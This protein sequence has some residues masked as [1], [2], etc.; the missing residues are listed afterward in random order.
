MA[1]IRPP[2]IEEPG[3]GIQGGENPVCLILCFHVSAQPA[4]LIRPRLPRIFHWQIR[5]HSARK[6]GPV[7]PQRARQILGAIQFELFVLKQSLHR[8]DGRRAKGAPVE[9]DSPA[10]GRVILHPGHITR[11]PW[12]SG[13]KQ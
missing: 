4:K 12:L 9:S 5:H 1:D 6:S 11:D 7:L 8:L 13:P 2:N 10:C 3:N